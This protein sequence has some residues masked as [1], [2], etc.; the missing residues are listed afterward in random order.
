M[1]L[2]KRSRIELITHHK[3]IEYIVTASTN[4]KVTQNQKRTIDDMDT[5]NEIDHFIKINNKIFFLFSS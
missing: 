3:N 4:S 2:Q 5:D 1:P